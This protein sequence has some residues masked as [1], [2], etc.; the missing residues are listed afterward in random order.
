MSARRRPC[1]P[2]RR[3][4]AGATPARLKTALCSEQHPRHTVRVR[5]VLRIED[6]VALGLRVGSHPAREHTPPS[7]TSTQHTPTR[8]CRGSCQAGSAAGAPFLMLLAA[9]RGA[10][11]AHGCQRGDVSAGAVAQQL[12]G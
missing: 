8:G 1:R 11:G 5:M 4:C 2:P 9:E 6:A 7:L 10:V 3:S 12:A